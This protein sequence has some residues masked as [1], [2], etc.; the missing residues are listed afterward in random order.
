VSG[1]NKGGGK[2]EVATVPGGGV[3]ARV[4][5]QGKGGSGGTRPRK[6]TWEGWIGARG[7]KG[8]GN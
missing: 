8:G 7:G 3:R 6:G 1:C 4:L 5:V 2:R